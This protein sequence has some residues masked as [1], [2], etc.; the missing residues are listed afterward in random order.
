M[1]HDWRVEEKKAIPGREREDW[2]YKDLKGS[3]AL[4]IAMDVH[5][6]VM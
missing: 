6:V 3:G 4:M 1:L 2:E 5:L